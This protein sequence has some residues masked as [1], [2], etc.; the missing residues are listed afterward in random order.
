MTKIFKL[1]LENQG[2]GKEGDICEVLRPCHP[3]PPKKKNVKRAL[4]PQFPIS[5]IISVKAAD[6]VREIMR[7]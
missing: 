2:G 7:Y 3:P 5:L 1:C 4:R 6:K